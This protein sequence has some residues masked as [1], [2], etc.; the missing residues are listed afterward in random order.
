MGMERK[1]LL[2]VCLASLAAIVLVL[3]LN[4]TSL[5]NEPQQ[6]SP[7][8]LAVSPNE[9]PNN[10][11][12]TI[13]ITGTGF[14]AVV[15]GTQ[16]LT[17]PVV[18]LDGFSLA[19]I[20]WVSSSTLT[21]TVPW[22]LDPG[23]YTATVMN[24]D[25]QFGSL[26][27][28]FTVTQAIGVW[29]T[30]GPYGGNVGD[31]AASP[32]FSQTAFATVHDVGLFRTVDG[33][34]WWHLVIRDRDV[35]GVKYGI[36]PAY[37]VYYWGSTGLWRSD[38]EGQ[39]FQQ[40]V[41][42]LITAFAPDPLNAQQLWAA[43]PSDV[44]YT[45]NGGQDWEARSTGLPT[46]TWLAWLTVDPVTPSTL[47]AVTA[48]GQVHKTIDSGA[49]WNPVGNGLPEIRHS[50]RLAV[51][52]FVPDVLLYCNYGALGTGYRSSD[53]GDSW[54][55]IEVIG[56]PGSDLTDFAF[57]PFISGTVY[58]SDGE[59]GESAVNVSTDGG[60]TWTVMSHWHS[61]GLSGIAL[62][63]ATGLPHYIASGSAGTWRSR[64]GGQTW[65]LATEGIAGLQV[66]DI[67]DSPSQP[68]TVYMAGVGAGGFVSENAGRSWQ[69]L[70]APLVYVIS[71][72]ADPQ[73]GDNIY[74]N[75]GAE[76]SYSRDGGLTWERGERFDPRAYWIMV[77]VAPSEPAALY[78]GGRPSFAPWLGNIGLAARSDDYGV[79]W[80]LLPLTST[81]PVSGLM[82]I[83]VDPTDAQTVYV[84]AGSHT[85][86][87]LIHPGKGLFRSTD[88]GQTWEPRKNGIGDVS[89]W[90]LAF[91]PVQSQTM[92]ASG[93]L[94]GE[95]KVTVFK[96]TDGSATWQ[97]TSLRIDNENPVAREVAVAIDPLAPD[98]VYVG[99]G[100]GLF[101]T[102]DGGET[103][104]R[105]AGTLGYARIAD[106]STVSFGDRT[107]LYVGVWGGDVGSSS[108]K[109]TTQTISLHQGYIQSGVYQYTDA[110]DT[111]AVYLPLVMRDD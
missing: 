58:A 108:T 38:D 101:R 66:Q 30:G 40:V 11:D 15:S 31:I 109:D 21:A 90:D 63:A 45:A 49:H 69:R 75:T 28:A 64:D 93:W 107:I 23:V 10:L 5:G 85:E 13:V 84:M 76:I 33:G 72:A 86:D 102:I 36:A 52:P 87:T 51:N 41:D 48:D 61:S 62:N 24:P 35:R 17:S 96:T 1:L 9:A 59:G 6:D 42:Y 27:D 26:P 67:A 37:P 104:S 81:L 79:T 100:G 2:S 68:A 106:V 32:V 14:Q 19:D 39:S 97:P 43:T 54:S 92:Y 60:A 89:V 4:T 65:E 95:E 12:T 50:V 91:H 57:S 103:W 111:F 29:T 83:V 25:G 110:H 16:V 47:Y 46:D 44:L 99:D 18:S 34:N 82:N 70:S 94:S 73:D 105:A 71:I 74:V 56:K 98:T 80:T 55:P 77:D 78:A 22:G 53:G 88:G 3:F 8:V 20:G 7:T